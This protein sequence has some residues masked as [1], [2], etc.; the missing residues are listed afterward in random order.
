MLAL[1][2]LTTSIAS[3]GATGIVVDNTDDVALAVEVK[4]V[5]D[6]CG[7][8]YETRGFN[9]GI[10]KAHNI[11]IR[12]AKGLGAET[13]ILL[14]QDTRISDDLIPRLVV[15][16]RDARCKNRRVVAV[17]PRSYDHRDGFNLVPTSGSFGF[18]FRETSLP[19]HG[20]V[21]VPFLISSGTLVHIDTWQ[22]VGE[23]RT[24]YFIDHVDVEWG[25]RANLAGYSI[26]AVCD[27]PMAHELA[28]IRTTSNG[29]SVRIHGH[30]VRRYY[31]VR[32]YLLL[33]RDLAMP[34]RWRLGL[35]GL[36]SRAM[37]SAI[38]RPPRRS[39]SVNF[40]LRGFRD[41]VRNRRGALP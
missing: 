31:Q 20:L 21:P 27:L 1:R 16:L 25:L 17:G 37:L 6:R 24:E 23:F 4:A 10:A 28:K 8:V 32:N 40:A 41:G 26:L 3:L 36:L 30:P 34:I 18:H 38:V 2:Q 19:H 39:S 13:A 33:Q 11:G 22:A 35:L 29:K 7:L 15:E 9:V 12:A 5:A 14:D